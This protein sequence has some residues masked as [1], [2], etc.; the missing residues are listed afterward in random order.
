MSSVFSLWF[1]LASLVLIAP[2]IDRKLAFRASW[3][4]VALAVIFHVV[5]EL[6]T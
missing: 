1:L 5:E 2:H 6:L 3:V 4:C